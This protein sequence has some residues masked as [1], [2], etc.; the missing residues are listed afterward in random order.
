M[1]G[2][3]LAFRESPHCEGHIEAGNPQKKKKKKKNYAPS[4]VVMIISECPPCRFCS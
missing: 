1:N 2:V 4:L 3:G